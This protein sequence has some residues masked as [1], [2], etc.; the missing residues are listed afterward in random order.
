MRTLLPLRLLL[1]S[2]SRIHLGIV[3]M[4]L[5]G[6]NTGFH[7]RLSNFAR[8][9]QSIYIRKGTMSVRQYLM[10]AELSEHRLLEVVFD[11]FLWFFCDSTLFCVVL[12]W[13]PQRWASSFCAGRGCTAAVGRLTML[14]TSTIHVISTTFCTVL[15]PCVCSPLYGYFRPTT[16]LH[17]A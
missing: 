9:Y 1:V 4:T 12:L 6:E 14:P 16:C 17:R 8:L 5:F 15:H 10:T 11:V 3:I 7:G 13:V 2:F